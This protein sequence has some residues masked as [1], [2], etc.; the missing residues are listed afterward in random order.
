MVIIVTDATA[1][2][3]VAFV[4]PIISNYFVIGHECFVNQMQCI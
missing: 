1:I 4:I 2:F 3:I